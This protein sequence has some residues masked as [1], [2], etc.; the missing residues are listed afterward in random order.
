MTNKFFLPVAF[1]VK[2]Y[3]TSPLCNTPEI[4]LFL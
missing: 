1:L 3:H 2:P 4:H